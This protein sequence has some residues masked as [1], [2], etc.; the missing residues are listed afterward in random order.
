MLY[1]LMSTKRKGTFTK[2]VKKVIKG[3][4]LLTLLSAVK[5][6]GGEVTVQYD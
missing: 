2:L 6:N 4:F 3:F 1:T 5:I